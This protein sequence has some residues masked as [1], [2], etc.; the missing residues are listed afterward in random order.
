MKIIVRD[1]KGIKKCLIQYRDVKYL[2]LRFDTP[3]I[4]DFL[5]R[6]IDVSKLKDSDFIEV[7]N[8]EVARII[9]ENQNIVDFGECVKYDN[10]TLSRLIILAHGFYPSEKEKL[11]EERKVEDMQDIIS[12]KNGTLTYQIP[13][14]YSPIDVLA[15]GKVVFGNSTIP[16]Y[17]VLKSNDQDFD[18][19]AFLEE[20]VRKLFEMVKPEEELDHY[21]V[22]KVDDCLLV[23]FK[24]N[25]K[26]RNEKRITV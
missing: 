10:L 9:D 13:V 7:K 1:N 26:L 18:L 23:Y 20:N 21:G 14:L 17:Y 22:S 19:T 11:D 5:L 2:G 15:D 25:K 16:G 24:G 8:A 12:L 4:V 3:K 6:D